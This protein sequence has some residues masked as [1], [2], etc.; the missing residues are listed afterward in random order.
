MA[1]GFEE[2]VL[3]RGEALLRFALMLSGD[4][5]AA[6]DLVQ[7]VLARAYPRWSRISAM[8]QPVAYLKAALVNEHL[9]WW[10][11]RSSRELPVAELT[12]REVAR[13]AAGREAVRAAGWEVADPASA[14][15]SRDAAWALLARLPRRQRAVLVLRYYEDLSDAEIAAI[16]RC[17]PATVRSQAARALATLRSALPTMDKEALP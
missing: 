11:R 10:R 1:S 17:A 13:Q 6:E 5:H 16:L 14:Y 15:A 12:D 8:E 9:R 4:R 2:L 7:T 3:A